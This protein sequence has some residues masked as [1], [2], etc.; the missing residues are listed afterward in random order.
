MFE[1]LVV[2]AGFAGSV[3][4]R[5]LAEY[6]CRVL[7]IDQRTHIGGNAFDE[8]DDAGILVHRYGAHIFHTKSERVWSYL[9]RFTTWRR[10]EH[11]VRAVVNGYLLPIPINLETLS[12]FARGMTAPLR[13][14]TREDAIR[15]LDAQRVPCAHPR[16]AEEQ[17]LATV[18]RALYEALIKPYTRKQWGR[19]PVELDASV[20]ARIPIRFDDEDR[21]FA[22]A[23]HQ[24]IPTDGYTRL[25]HRLIDHPRI[26]L[27]LNTSFEDIRHAG[28]H[29]AVIYT[30]PIDQFFG[31]RFGRLPYRSA[32]FE[33]VRLN[34]AFAQACGVINYPGSGASW[35]RSIEFKHLTGQDHVHTTVAYEIPS[36][37]G[38]PF[39]PVPS[40]E[41]RAV[42]ADYRA[43]AA[44]KAPEVSFCGRLGSYQYLD[45]DQAVGSALALSSRVITARKG[46]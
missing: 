27:M 15:W 11:R 45:I 40:P 34:K 4:A 35:T 33:F 28:L 17:S 31:Y 30:G 6:G 16:N 9:S 2:G 19:D 24:G 43:L 10:Y 39:W 32:R 13:Q 26:K 1:Y 36:A 42:A 38:E 14:V 46:L 37:T 20:T 3:C 29:E 41:S 22:D 12:V 7:L 18:G 44:A 23:T 5:E 21:Y 8:Y 25:F